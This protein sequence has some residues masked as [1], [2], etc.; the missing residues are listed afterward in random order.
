MPDARSSGSISRRSP[1]LSRILRRLSDNIVTHRPNSA[2][3]SALASP[4]AAARRPASAVSR[5]QPRRPLRWFWS[6]KSQAHS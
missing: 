6:T 2:P 1:P 4:P 3:T 5:Q